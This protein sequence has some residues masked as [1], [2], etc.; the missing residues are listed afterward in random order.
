MD[1][2]MYE[3]MRVVSLYSMHAVARTSCHRASHGIHDQVTGFSVPLNVL[4]NFWYRNLVTKCYCFAVLL[5]STFVF[6]VSEHHPS[7]TSG[8]MFRLARPVMAFFVYL[9]LI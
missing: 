6:Q 5:V 9:G 8:R 3:S 7:E 1:V 2:W 4:R